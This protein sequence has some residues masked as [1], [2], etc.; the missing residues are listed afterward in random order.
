[1]PARP[2]AKVR[3]IEIQESTKAAK[4]AA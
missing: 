2:E 1:L 4:S 3:K